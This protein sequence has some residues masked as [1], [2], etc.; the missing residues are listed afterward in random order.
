MALIYHDGKSIP[1]AYPKDIHSDVWYGFDY[2]LE[3]GETI[4]SSAWLIDGVA[5]TNA[6]D[7]VNGMA[8]QAKDTAGQY[9]KLRLTGGIVGTT[10]TITNRITTTSTPSDDRSMYITGVEL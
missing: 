7:S 10:Y 4:T 5:V 8:Y 3:T 6:G 2:E 9:T 1:T